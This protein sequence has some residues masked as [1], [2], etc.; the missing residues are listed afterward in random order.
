LLDIVAVG[1]CVKVLVN[2]GVLVNVFVGP[3]GV[4]VNVAVGPAGVLVNVAVAATGV[5]VGIAV[6]AAGQL[7]Q[8]YMTTSSIQKSTGA[9]VAGATALKLLC[10]CICVAF[11]NTVVSTAD[12]PHPAACDIS[13]NG[14]VNCVH[15][16]GA[17]KIYS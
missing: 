9:L 15:V 12:V 14:I 5:F 16:A 2:V 1:T 8:P 17:V 4:F 11:F 10:H 3:N 6:G 7:G 13:A